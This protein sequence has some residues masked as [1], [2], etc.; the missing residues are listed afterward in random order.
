MLVIS[1]YNEDVRDKTI[2][3]F[4]CSQYISFA[5]MMKLFLMASHPNFLFDIIILF[6]S[7][8]LALFGYA[9]LGFSVL[10]PQL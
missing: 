9:D 7:R 1:C 10:F 3:F 4:I 5:I 6:S 2:I 8:Q